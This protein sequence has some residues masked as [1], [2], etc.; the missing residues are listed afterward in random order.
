MMKLP[1]KIMDLIDGKNFAHVA[2]IMKDGSPQVSA[3]WI[4]REG[5]VI[6][7]N[8]AEGRVKYNNLKRDGRVAISIADATN[9][10]N[11]VWIRGKVVEMTS[12]GADEHID[13]LAKKY[14]GK[15]KYPWKTPTEKRVIVR[16]AAER[17]NSGR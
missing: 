11:E 8:T 4:D 16:I 10:Y 6:V 5:D 2:T 1:Q 17:I 12:K 14:L 7:F 9:P 15:D 3:V 13:M